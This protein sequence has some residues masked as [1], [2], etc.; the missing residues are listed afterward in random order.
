[1][2]FSKDVHH[3]HVVEIDK[4]TKLP[5]LTG[6]LRESLK[7]LKLMPAFQYIMLRLRVKKAACQTALNEGFELDEKKLRYLQAGVFWAGD[8]ERDIRILT[9][10]QTTSRPPSNDELEN[11]KKIQASLTL[12]DQH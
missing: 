1:M 5:E 9:Q 8:I 2:I 11:F 10:D 4:E 12:I 7:A 6:D 3:Y